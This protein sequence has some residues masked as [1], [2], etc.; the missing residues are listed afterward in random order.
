MELG[1]A[2]PILLGPSEHSPGTH[3]WHRYEPFTD[4]ASSYLLLRKHRDESPS[5][6]CGVR[7]T[8]TLVVPSKGN[9]GSAEETEPGDVAEPLHQASLRALLPFALP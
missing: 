6:D 9:I 3:Y 5:L 8:L 2:I 1:G 7:V 4:A